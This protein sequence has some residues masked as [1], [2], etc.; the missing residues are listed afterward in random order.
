[1]VDMGNFEKNS[2]IDI[3]EVIQTITTKDGYVILKGLFNSQDIQH[4]RKTILYLISKQGR[5]ATHFQVYILYLKSI[6]YWH[7][8]NYLL[9]LNI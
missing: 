7:Y 2:S 8:A 6:Y 9:I 5:K 1:M 3:A 4:A